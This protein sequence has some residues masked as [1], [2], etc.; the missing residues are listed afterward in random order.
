MWRENI[1]TVSAGAAGSAFT[2]FIG[3]KR[4]QSRVNEHTDSA[5]LVPIC[6]IRRLRRRM[7]SNPDHLLEIAIAV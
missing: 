7:G 1:E 2:Q 5:Q 6:R 4:G 3:L